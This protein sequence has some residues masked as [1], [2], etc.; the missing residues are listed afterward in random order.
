MKCSVCFNTNDNRTIEAYD[1]Y[2]GHS[3]LYLSCAH[4]GS[5]ILQDV[6]SNLASY[7]AKGYY[8]FIDSN[9]AS[10]LGS[11]KQKRDVFTFTRKGMTGGLLNLFSRNANLVALRK[12]QLQ[13]E[14]SV[15]DIGCGS[16]K[17]IRLLRDL[18]YQYVVGADPFIDANIMYD[19]TVLVYKASLYDMHDKYDVITL[20]HS[21][22]HMANPLQVLQH[23][24]NLL[25]PGGKLV[26]RIPLADS[27]AFNKYGADWVQL[28]APRHLYLHTQKGMQILAHQA[29]LA[30]A[31][32]Q[33][34]SL[35]MQFWGSR[36]NRSGFNIH[37]QPKWK[38]LFY[39]FLSFLRGEFLTASHLNARQKG[40]QA[41]FVLISD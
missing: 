8:S 5:L 37:Q 35:S 19:N 2:S 33:H 10:L 16:G 27:H 24:K 20:H 23:I 32:I 41:M 13:K 12:I 29:G 14:Q 36:L 15:L 26:I 9:P 7:Y 40:D 34:D 3:F 1:R 21:F 39:R 22:E 25:K 18:G 6:P 28:D 17:E 38:L 11:F 30:I 4:C 31:S